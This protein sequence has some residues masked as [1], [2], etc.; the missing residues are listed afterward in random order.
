MERLLGNREYKFERIQFV[1][2]STDAARAAVM[3]PGIEPL[4]KPI[5]ARTLS[6]VGIELWNVMA[7]LRC[8]ACRNAS[9]LHCHAPQ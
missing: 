2:A 6:V 5:K 7:W 8:L 9:R 4:N 3:P 1:P